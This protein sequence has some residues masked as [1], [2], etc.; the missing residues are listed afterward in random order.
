MRIVACQGVLQLAAHTRAIQA[1]FRLQGG[2]FY[3]YM[4][5]FHHLCV[6]L[7]ADV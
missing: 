7:L 3:A 2:R 1:S 5:N 4:P 6:Y